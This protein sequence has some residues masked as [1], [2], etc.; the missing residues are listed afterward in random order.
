MINYQNNFLIVYMNENKK[1][2]KYNKM[3]ET[4]ILFIR[5]EKNLTIKINRNLD[6]IIET[7]F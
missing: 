6:F 2:V 1:I 7:S 4:I 3:I 5:I